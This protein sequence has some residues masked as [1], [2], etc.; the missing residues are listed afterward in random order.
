MKITEV[1]FPW[2]IRRARHI[3]AS[4]IATKHALLDTYALSLDKIDVIYPGL[5]DV[6]SPLENSVRKQEMR[7]HFGAPKGY[8]LHF[9][10]QSDPRDNT[11]VALRAFHVSQQLHA[12]DIKLVIAGKTNPDK[13]KLS[14]VVEEL[15]LFDQVIWAGFIPEKDLVDVYRSAELYFDPSLYEGFGYQVLEAMACGTPVVC[16]NVTSLPE[17]VGTA[18]LISPPMDIYSFAEHIAHVITSAE[19]ATKMRADGIALA[20]RFSW[21]K[22]VTQLMEAYDRALASRDSH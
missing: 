19:V 7:V 17:I 13:Q 20:H 2:S 11:E 8:I 9:S 3:F 5:D 16:S 14:P 4:S 21:H 12:H 18:A 6:F 15:G 22:T 1:I 10:S